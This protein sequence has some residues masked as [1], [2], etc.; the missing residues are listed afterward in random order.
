M[1][2]RK[3]TAK[4]KERTP[5]GLEQVVGQPVYSVWVDMLRRLVPD[6]RTHRLA[7]TI[8]AMLQYTAEQSGDEPEE[9]TVAYALA[10]AYD[11]DYDGA[12]EALLPIVEKLFDDAKVKFRRTSA[13]G[14]HYSIAQEAVH[15]FVDWF[16]MPWE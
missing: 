2:S 11:A 15:E 13:A 8:A 14:E 6:G 9:G 16:N 5:E 12:E 4:R 3:V 10:L 1:A 7:T